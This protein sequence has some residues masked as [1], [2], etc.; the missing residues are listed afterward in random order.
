[1]IYILERGSISNQKRRRTEDDRADYVLF[2]LLHPIYLT[3]R[4]GPFPTTAV[5]GVV[6]LAAEDT[7]RR[8]QPSKEYIKGRNT[9]FIQ[10]N[11]RITLD[12]VLAILHFRTSN[13][14]RNIQCCMWLPCRIKE[15]IHIVPLNMQKVTKPT[16]QARSAMKIF[17]CLQILVG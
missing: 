3:H 9:S 4:F 5:A 6:I 14:C 8:T 13:L 11:R 1:M 12:I 17:E 2:V 7:D 16:L 15:N 10:A